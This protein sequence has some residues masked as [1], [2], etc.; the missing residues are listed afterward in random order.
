MKLLPMIHKRISQMGKGE[1]KAPVYGEIPESKARDDK[2]KSSKNSD[3]DNKK[4]LANVSSLFPSFKPGA[5]DIVFFDGHCGLCHRTVRFLLARDHDGVLFRFAPLDSK[6]FHSSFSERE[7]NAF[8]ESLIVCTGAGEVLT[9]STASLY[10]LRR[11]GGPWR[12]LSRL[13]AF[14][15]LSVRDAMYDGIARMRHHLFAAP[16]EEC[17]LIPPE[18]RSRFLE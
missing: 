11:L 3:F 13:L 6:T 14:V 9:R 4:S 1:I 15:P 8:P 12:L 2:E 7:R 5:V 16:T 18:L 10:L 17:P